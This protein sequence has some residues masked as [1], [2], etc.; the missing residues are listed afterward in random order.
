MTV[1]S[2]LF[3]EKQK[4]FNL[5]S[6]GHA[7]LS[8]S[9]DTLLSIRHS[10]PYNSSWIGKLPYY[11]LSWLLD[12]YHLVY[13]YSGFDGKTI[14]GFAAYFLSIVKLMNG[15]FKVTTHFSGYNVFLWSKFFKCKWI[16][17]LTKL[18]L[19]GTRFCLIIAWS[20]WLH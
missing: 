17:L 16:V 12:L 20:I 3:S 15:S 13:V 1:I 6:L 14:L 9:L 19:V 8:F 18:T 7:L 11:F 2:S 4:F 10:L 5:H